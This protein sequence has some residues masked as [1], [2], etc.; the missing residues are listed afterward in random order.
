[1]ADGRDA[2][3]A[4]ARRALMLARRSAIADFANSA[5]LAP[6]D[7]TLL[8]IECLGRRPICARQPGRTPQAAGAGRGPRHLEPAAIDLVRFVR[9]D[10]DVAVAIFG[11]RAADRDLLMPA[12]LAAY[13][14]RLHGENQV[15]MYAGVLPP[16][17]LGVGIGARKRPDAVLRAFKTSS[18]PSA[19]SCSFAIESPVRQLIAIKPTTY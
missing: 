14:V 16:H 7:F 15:L 19:V 8:D 2:L 6:P 18:L 5:N 9:I 12:M 17:A 13:G 10:K 11:S 4:D 1:M 3:L